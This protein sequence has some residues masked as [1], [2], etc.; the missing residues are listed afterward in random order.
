MDD[1]DSSES[2]HLGEVASTQKNPASQLPQ[3]RHKEGERNLGENQGKSSAQSSTKPRDVASRAVG[4]DNP[5]SSESED[6]GEVASTQKISVP[7][8]QQQPPQQRHEEG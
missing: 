5:D 1:P 8:S 3:Q 4:M 6:L 7:Q 2:E